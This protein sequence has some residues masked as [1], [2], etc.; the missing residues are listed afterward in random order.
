LE[1]YCNAAKCPYNNKLTVPAL[2]NFD[3]EHYKAFPGDTYCGKCKADKNFFSIIYTETEKLQT[4]EPACGGT[5]EDDLGKRC[6]MSE[7]TYNEDGDCKRSIIFVGE[8]SI[9]H[10]IVCKNYSRKFVSGH[11][12]IYKVMGADGHPKGGHLSDAEAK[13]LDHDNRVSKS[14]PGHFRE[15]KPRAK[16]G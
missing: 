5:D 2:L 12:N 13:R 1:I 11:I 6:Y 3:N 16:R 14:F 7:C 4:K 9:S 15:S 10:G 8:S